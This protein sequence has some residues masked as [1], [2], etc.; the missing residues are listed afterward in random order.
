M[1][2]KLK[3]RIT[4]VRRAAS[5]KKATAYVL[6]RPRFPRSHTRIPYGSWRDR[7]SG[8]NGALPIHHPLAMNFFSSRIFP[9]SIYY[10][11]YDFEKAATKSS[12]TLINCRRQL[13]R[14]SMAPCLRFKAS[15]QSLRSCNSK[16]CRKNAPHASESDYHDLH[17]IAPFNLKRTFS[18][19]R[20]RRRVGRSRPCSAFAAGI[21]LSTSPKKN[22]RTEQRESNAIFLSPVNIL[23]GEQSTRANE[24]VWASLR[25]QVQSFRG[26]KTETLYGT[27]IASIRKPVRKRGQKKN[28]RFFKRCP[29]QGLPG[30]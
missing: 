21:A 2:L 26:R 22:P 4:G 30:I 15:L 24:S 17:E 11:K 28:G 23:N 8:T 9:C 20:R 19:S 27:S 29:P 5:R 1:N 16:P 18:A 13:L 14:K 10:G 7:G 25:N 3:A 12:E 6:G